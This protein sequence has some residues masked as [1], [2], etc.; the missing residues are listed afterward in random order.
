MI[1]LVDFPTRK[2]IIEWKCRSVL[3]ETHSAQKP[4]LVC[5]GCSFTDQQSHFD[6]PLYWPGYLVAR[7]AFDHAIDLSSGGAG[8][9]YITTSMLNQL[10]TMSDSELADVL[11]IIVWSGVSRVE[12]LVARHKMVGW[13]GFID[14]VQYL[15]PIDS[16]EKIDPDVARAEVLRSWKNMVLLENYLQLR[17]ITYGFS[18]YFNV[19]DPPFL[20]RCVNE[21]EFTGWLDSRK[22]ARLRQCQWLHDHQQS[23]YE[24][25]F[26]LGLTLND[27]FHPSPHGSLRW[28]DDVL[29]PSLITRGLVNQ[30]V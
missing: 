15:R 23:M 3:P 2:K 26:D 20:P 30:L 22:V 14:T 9:E 1:N 13:E 21:V 7:C 17:N 25:C 11:V 4:V 27:M 8:N 10:E 29:I 12:Q 19:F 18:F 28:T 5:S 16:Q 6:I 24:F